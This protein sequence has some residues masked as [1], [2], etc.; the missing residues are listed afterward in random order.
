MPKYNSDGEELIEI[1]KGY[2]IPKSLVLTEEEEKAKK[3]RLERP[4]FSIKRILI[5]ILLLMLV[6]ATPILVFF[7]LLNHIELWI[8]ICG[9][10]GFYILYL[11]IRLKSLVIFMIRAYQRFAPMETRERCNMVPNCSNYMILAIKKYGLIKGMNKGW[12]RLKRC[13]QSENNI[14]YP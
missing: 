13:G 11:V 9:Y 7:V 2:W 3:K 1:Q 5:E 6:I 10:T 12:K 14:D 4:K 8:K